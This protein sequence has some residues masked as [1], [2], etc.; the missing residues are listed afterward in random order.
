MK[1]DKKIL[2]G[3]LVLI[4]IIIIAIF[5]VA[6]A[7]GWKKEENI[8]N[9]EEGKSQSLIN[10]S[11]KNNL[12]EDNT[13]QNN[14]NEDYSLE[15]AVQNGHFVI[16]HN[17]IYN[18][19]KL[20]K[21]I[22]NTSINSKNRIED[23][24][25]I[26]QYTTE[27][28]PIIT[29]LSYKIKDETY[30]HDGETINKTTYILKVDNT[31]DKWSVQ[32]DRKVITNDDIPGNLYGITETKDG[33]MVNVDLALY[34]EIDYA[35]ENVKRYEAIHICSYPNNEQQDST[36]SFYAKV[37]EA[38]SKYI[39]VQP[40]EDEEI[41]KSSD[42]IQIDLGED[43]DA[44]YE[45]GT[46]VKITYKG[47][48]MET[49]PAKVEA[50]NIEAKSNN[51]FEIRFYDKQP[52][53]ET[54]VH[55]ILD[56]SETDKYDYNI[57]TYNGSVNILINKEEMSL[58]DALINNKITMNE[59]IIKANQDLK[60]KK[61]T[62]DMYRDGGSMIYQYDNYTIIKCHTLDG[63]RDVY[64]GTPDLTINDLSV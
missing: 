15:K 19:H 57:Y 40:N 14:P 48:I 35:D 2:I 37:I 11:N 28:D 6:R 23:S 20:D 3:M 36:T 27:G 59:I 62:G 39:L 25:K 56:K 46:N 33:D 55:K 21:F 42:K 24:I 44:I 54:K 51:K 49:Y 61:I 10:N 8:T 63:N 53:N 50:V 9:Q 30:S 64:I 16:T 32:E 22:E 18:K 26:V 43:N 41:R 17:K 7:K 52:Q 1:K 60:D 12:N 5:F 34:A 29:E 58:R 31:R 38:N 13:N 47:Y 45:I 4:T